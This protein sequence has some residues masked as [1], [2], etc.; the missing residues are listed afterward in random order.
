M[1]PRSE[2]APPARLGLYLCLLLGLGAAGCSNESTA[3]RIGDP[4]FSDGHVTFGVELA[5]GYDAESVRFYLDGRRIAAPFEA[6]AFHEAAATSLE[7]SVPIASGRH[8]LMVAADFEVQ[9]R[10]TSRFT[11]QLFTAPAGA[12]ALAA[13]A[14]RPGAS[15]VPTTAW[16]DLHFEA[17]LPE[18]L[19]DSFRLRCGDVERALLSTALAPARIVLN[20]EG[21][22][23]ARSACRLTWRGENGPDVLEFTTATR[24]GAGRVLY[25]R[26]RTDT[27]VPFPDDFYTRVDDDTETGLRLDVPVPT[28]PGVDRVFGALLADVNIHDGFSPIAPLVI[29]LSEPV[30]PDGVPRTT[31][32]SLDPLAPIALID[33]DP[34]SPEYGRRVPFRLEDRTPSVERA[35]RAPRQV[36]LL[37][38]STPLRP[39]GRYGLLVT[40]RARTARGRPYAPTA[41]MAAVLRPGP[42]ARQLPVLRARAQIEPV[43]Q[44]AEKLLVPPIPREDLALALHFTVQSGAGLTDDLLAVRRKVRAAPPPRYW[45]ERVDRIDDADAP[46]AALVHGRWEA[47]EWRDGPRFARDASGLPV[48]TGTNLV[49]FTLSLP[50]SAARGPAP[51]VMYQHGNPGDAMG[52]ISS[53]ARDALSEAGFAIVGTTDVLNREISAEGKGSRA[54]VT[55]QVFAMLTAVL[56]DGGVPDYWMQTY[57]EQIAFLRVIEQLGALDVLPVGAP[58]GRPDVDPGASLGYVGMSEGANHAAAF[59][60]YAPEIRA[61]ALVGGGSRLAELVIHQEAAA[62]VRSVPLVLPGFRDVD[63]WLGLALFQAAFD[64]QDGHNH[65]RYLYRDPLPIGTGPD[66]ASVLLISGID[67]H[68]VPNHATRSLA[69]QL[70]PI[71]QL[72]PVARRAPFLESA[73][74]PLVANIG[75]RTTAGYVQYVPLGV[76]GLLPTPG[77]TPPNLPLEYAWEGHFCAQLARESQAQRARFLSSALGR[78]APV[79]D[80]TPPE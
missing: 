28:R 41:S 3:V 12:P 50:R 80:W 58:D 30:D 71:P 15:D 69:W 75:P 10:R 72:E 39:G 37:F 57:A 26:R 29:E 22:L 70:G 64:R 20:P 60:P 21:Q 16:L 61:A 32:A 55:A 9:G 4:T 2:S 6:F 7:F 45:V 54:V 40:R 27:L 65:A 13:A 11:T 43:L 31:E 48:Q 46:V 47:P 63:I 79:I 52:E 25:D 66:R 73:P 74:A 35:R 77:C 36:L 51:L 8:L 14:P 78:G 62:F 68:L 5:V 33:V 49:P 53:P 34:I 56:M 38:P 67:D 42:P 59:L 19:L 23:P 1:R 17:A 18:A 24:R 76:A 44:V